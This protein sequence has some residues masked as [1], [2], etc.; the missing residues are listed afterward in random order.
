VSATRRWAS[1]ASDGGTPRRDGFFAGTFVT[2]MNSHFDIE[3]ADAVRGPQGLVYD[4]DGT[5]NIVSKRAN[6]NRKSGR[7]DFR[8]D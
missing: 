8:T 2:G 7:T 4:A 1:A 5:V 3:R 6:F